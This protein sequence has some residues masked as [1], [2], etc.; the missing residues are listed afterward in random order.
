MTCEKCQKNCRC[1]TA[2]SCDSCLTGYGLSLGTC[3][4][5]LND[6]EEC[7]VADECLPGKCAVGFT[8]VETTC[9][10]CSSTCRQCDKAGQG[11]CDEEGCDPHNGYD[12]NLQ[13]CV[14]CEISE[15]ITCKFNAY[16][17]QTCKKCVDGFG[18]TSAGTCSDC[19]VGC[20]KC[21]HSGSCEECI[22]SYGRSHEGLCLRCADQCRNCTISGPGLCDECN[23]RFQM[24][25]HICTPKHGGDTN[26][27]K[28]R[29]GKGEEL[30]KPIYQ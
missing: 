2:G 25:N 15:C 21:E 4:P 3:V 5:C 23:T 22:P 16:S 10:P 6:C 12:P 27:D 14:P 24:E 29:K 1:G 26:T 13:K 7:V 8:N 11:L 20:S 19:G 30:T 18:L 9:K 28:K 17:H